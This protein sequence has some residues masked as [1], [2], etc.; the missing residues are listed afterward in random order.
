MRELTAPVGGV[1]LYASTKEALADLFEEE[2]VALGV[3][4]HDPASGIPTDLLAVETDQ[5]LAGVSI[6]PAVRT[7]LDAFAAGD[8]ARMVS[9]PTGTWFVVVGLA[10]AA[11]GRVRHGGADTCLA[12]L[13][14]RRA[15][16]ASL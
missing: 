3:P 8:F 15:A 12:T 1:P 10:T 4:P 7:A 16:A 9:V 5:L 14:L 13:D 2:L 11:A 6:T